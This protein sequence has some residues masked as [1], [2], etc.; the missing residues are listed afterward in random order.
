MCS[1][2]LQDGA[3]S[4]KLSGKN[5]R[6]PLT[7]KIDSLWIHGTP[8]ETHDFSFDAGPSPKQGQ[9]WELNQKLDVMGQSI[10]I[11]KVTVTQLE[12]G[13]TGEKTDGYAF[14]LEIPAGFNL[15]NL[16]ES[17]PRSSV[18]ESKNASDGHQILEVGYPDGLPT[19]KLTYHVQYMV[20]NLKGS[21]QSEWV[22]PSTSK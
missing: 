7:L 15:I 3:F 5:W 14:D 6:S 2:D 11:R 17:E 19:G 8:A 22:I 4:Y 18:S 20:Y 10:I 21:W 9:S 12:D 13:A 1:S 16:A